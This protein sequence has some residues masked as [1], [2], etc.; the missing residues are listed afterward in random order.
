MALLDVNDLSLTLRSDGTTL[1]ALR[2]LSF[3]L[4]A[5]ETLALVGESGCGKSM[6]ALAIMGLLPAASARITTGTIQF[7][8]QDL[9]RLSPKSYRQIRGQRI[10]MI[11]QYAMRALNPVKTVGAQLMEVLQ[12]HLNMTRRAARSRA[13]ALLERVKI[14]DAARRLNDYPH[15]MSGGMSQR[16]MI[17]MAIACQPQVLIAD[18]PTTALD[19]TIQAQILQLLRDIQRDTGM[20]LL[21]ITHD[22]GVVAAMA[23]RV[24]V[25]YAGQIIEQASVMELFDNPIHPYT[26]GLLRSTPKSGLPGERLFAIPGRVPPLNALPSGCAFR[27]RCPLARAACSEQIPEL[28]HPRG[29]HG[30]ACLVNA[31][32]RPRPE[33]SYDYIA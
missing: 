21:L 8:H 2:R 29:Q 23:Q 6:T 20:G 19:V 9:T 1:T 7:D 4:E 12:L 10:A 30:A 3:Q 15:Q 14:P 33:E 11:F 5:G 25:M 16:V 32:S 18:E 28:D 22:L 17:A 24:A 31:P 13:I 27:N 26:Q